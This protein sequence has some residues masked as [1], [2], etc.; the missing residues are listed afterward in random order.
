M[1]KYFFIVIL[2]CVVVVTVSAKSN[3]IN[4]DSLNNLNSKDLLTY[5]KENG[6]KAPVKICTYDY[7]EY[8]KYDNLE[9]AVKVYI[10]NY[11]NYVKEKTD[12]DTSVRVSLKGFKITEIHYES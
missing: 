9:K 2:F 8:L 4:I 11:I 3:S 6:G 5:L 10:N 12:E 7:C 1:K